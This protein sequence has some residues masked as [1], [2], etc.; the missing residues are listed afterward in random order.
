[1]KLE[2]KNLF[3]S[4]LL[5]TVLVVL[6]VG[7][8]IFMLPSLYLDYM[9][10]QNLA[11]VIEQQ[12]AYL[13]THSYDDVALK[14]P[15]ACFTVEI[16]D[17][18][19]DL[20]FTNNYMSA[21]IILQDQEMMDILQDI[22]TVFLNL[23]Q[24]SSDVGHDDETKKKQEFDDIIQ[25]IATYMS[26]EMGELKDDDL[27]V[28]LEIMRRRDGEDAYQ[29]EDIRY[30]F[31]SDDIFVVEAKAGDA[32]NEYTTYL[33]MTNTESSVVLSVLPAMSTRMG[34]IRDVVLNSLPMIVAVIV[35][36][37]LLFSYLYS[38]GIIKPLFAEV[39]RQN[40]ELDEKNRLLREEN[41][42][43]E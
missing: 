38:T 30:H 6:L 11:G 10:E 22:R 34:E 43:Q 27:P 18:G 39:K 21:R 12:K 19:Q 15:S 2:N 16:P 23:N 13:N 4:L 41:K 26:N 29:Y 14:N 25:R 35:L 33:A 7:Y 31:V 3:Y 37:V 42:R 20:I 5:A 17:E 28:S 32:Q 8:F 36:L 1:M 40:D 24:G 9:D